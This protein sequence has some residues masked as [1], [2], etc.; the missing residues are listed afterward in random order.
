MSKR[1]PNAV[2]VSCSGADSMSATARMILGGLPWRCES[3]G[4]Q[5]RDRALSWAGWNATL[6]TLQSVGVLAGVSKCRC[7]ANRH[8]VLGGHDARFREYFPT[9][10][11]STWCWSSVT[12]LHADMCF[13]CRLLRCVVLTRGSLSSCRRLAALF[14]NEVSQGKH[15]TVRIDARPSS[16]A[17]DRVSKTRGCC[18]MTSQEACALIGVLLAPRPSRDVGYP[19]FIAMVFYLTMACRHGDMARPSIL[20]TI[21]SGIGIAWTRTQGVLGNDAFGDVC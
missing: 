16:K 6:R 4:L 11:M 12:T 19:A 13:D 18:W 2:G 8:R 7:D 1:T 9:R 20:R 10:R 15:C 3:H 14:D 17:H 21:F 5:L